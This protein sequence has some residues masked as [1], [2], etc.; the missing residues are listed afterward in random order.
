MLERNAVLEVVA[1][2]LIQG[3]KVLVAQRPKKDRLAYKWEFPGGKI[4]KGESPED[5]LIREI[6]EEL[7][8]SIRVLSHF[9]TIEHLEPPVPLRLYAYFA[10]LQGGN[11]VPQ[12]QQNIQWIP[13]NELLSLD[14]APADI[15]LAQYLVS[16]L[17]TVDQE[18]GPSESL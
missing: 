3:E 17:N 16:Y 13:F 8:V 14:F 1:L 10:Q 2:L 11:P 4:E 12:E 7:G 15:P 6:Q 18:D 5:A 9:K